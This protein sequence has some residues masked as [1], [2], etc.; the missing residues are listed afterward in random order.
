MNSNTSST[1]PAGPTATS[2]SP[3]ADPTA[4]SGLPTD[5]TMSPPGPQPT[6]PPPPEPRRGV[7]P[8]VLGVALVGVV[9]LLFLLVK[10]MDGKQNHEALDQHPKPVTVVEAK[11]TTYREQRRY[12]GTLEPWLE[13][14]IG[15]QVVSAYIDTV[16]VRPGSLVKAGE[17][18]ATLDCRGASAVNRAVAMQARALEAHRRASAN[19]AARIKG[20]LDG[21]FASANEAEKKLAQSEAEQAQ[22]LAVQAKLSSASLQVN[23]CVLKAPF[24]GEIAARSADP[25]GFVRPGTSVVTLVDRA[26]V[27]VTADA[28]EADF[29]AVAPGSPVKMHLLA[30]NV[31]VNGVV[32]RRA[33]KA[34][35]ATRTIHFEVDVSDPSLSMPVGTTAELLIDV[36]TAVSA[37]ELPLIAA[38]VKGKRASAY[39]IEGDVAVAKTLVYLG[40]R[41]GKM[42]LR[43]DLPNGAKVVTAGRNA[44]TDGDKV[45]ATVDRFVKKDDHIVVAPPPAGSAMAAGSAAPP[46]GSAPHPGVAQ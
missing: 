30:T 5:D 40:E 29:A 26:T 44:L 24:A 31:D 34:D 17:V 18:L 37:L 23:D 38:N 20:L 33:P 15:P 25:G 19:E 12:I 1:S 35:P 11:A 16:L 9:S 10:R 21:G 46:A 8:I 41:E 3:S 7:V 27:R 2:T 13:A 39:V 6:D 43:P 22:L 14:K 4:P 45:I 28:P 36:G 42:F 32:T